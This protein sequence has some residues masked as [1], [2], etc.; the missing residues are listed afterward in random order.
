MKTEKLEFK[1]TDIKNLD[2]SIARK[3]VILRKIEQEIERRKYTLP[4]AP[5]IIFRISNSEEEVF[6]LYDYLQKNKYKIRTTNLSVSEL[7]EIDDWYSKVGQ[8]YLPNMFDVEK[9]EKMFSDY[10]NLKKSK[11]TDNKKSKELREK[12]IV[13]NIK[14]VNWIV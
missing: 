14:L 5:N 9:M 4:I 8:S 3:K 7:E 10:Y 13:E 12:L 1:K 6:Y 11:L 2:I